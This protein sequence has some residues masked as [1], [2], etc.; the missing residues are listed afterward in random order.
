MTGI[1]KIIED[2]WQQAAAGEMLPF[3]SWERLRGE[4]SA[5]YAAFCVYRDL[6][7]ERNIRKAVEA[8]EKEEGKPGKRYGMWRVW[9]AQFRWRERGMEYDR[10]LEGLKQTE[11]RKTIEEQGKVQRM[12]TGK[13]LQV[14]Y[15]K[16]EL[17]NPRD[18]TQ[19][20][21]K[22]WVETA[23]RADREATGLVTPNGGKAEPKQL[24]IQ[25]TP[26]FNGL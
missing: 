10:Y 8:Y 19:G 7:P 4:S 16:L 12:V 3:E 9:A 24:E 25:F 11:V 5:A 2:V 20:T 1:D 18:L 22:E 17:M 15:K 13:M 23:I 14:V 26:E 6:G 21:V